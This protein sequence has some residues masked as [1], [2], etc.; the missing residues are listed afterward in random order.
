MHATAA[1]SIDYA[2]ARPLQIS[3]RRV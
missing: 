1:K 2:V 3:A